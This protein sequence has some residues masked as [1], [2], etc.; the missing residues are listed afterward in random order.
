M[1]DPYE[2]AAIPAIDTHMHRFHPSRA[3]EF[4]TVA[5]GYVAGPGQADHARQTMLYRMVIETLRTH[6]QMPEDAPPA[7]VEAERCRR[8]AADPVAYSRDLLAGQNTALYCVETGSPMGGPAYTAEEIRHFHQVLPAERCCDIIRI[9][10]VAE[11]LLKEDLPFSDF[12]RRFQEDL[13]REIDSHRTVGLKSCCAYN[14]G[15]DVRPTD[16]EA[17]ARG[18]ERM[19]RGDPAGRKSFFDFLLLEGVEAAVERDL[20][21]QIHTGAGGGTWLDFRTENP[22]HLIDFLKDERVLD[23]CRIV[24]LH[25]GHPH[26]EDTGY[27]VSQ[28]ANVY[29][30]FS[31]TFYLCTGKSVERMTALL[32]RTPLNKVM[33]GSDGVGMP[34]LTWFAHDR[35]RQQLVKLLDGL[36]AEGCMTRP[37]AQEAARMFLRDNALDCYR[38]VR[39]YL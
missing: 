8:Y 25:G 27:L 4:G 24:L 37:R 26:E 33:Y 16:R 7:A 29:T 12:L 18:Y 15:L 13:R 11:E 2:I 39:G 21:I 36:V 38:A 34:E 23:R 14:G 32:E 17:A 19:R 20:P 22:I 6:F 10:R 30:D 9:D 5:G 31:G 35:F 28:F 1:I 3:G